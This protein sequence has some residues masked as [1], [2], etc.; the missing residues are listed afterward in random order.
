MALERVPAD[1]RKDGGVARMVRPSF[2]SHPLLRF[3]PPADS[4]ALPFAQSDPKM[5]KEIMAFVHLPRPLL[6]S[7]LAPSS[8]LDFGSPPRSC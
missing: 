8:R 4:V 6:D 1:I 2:P 7:I 3:A 5:I